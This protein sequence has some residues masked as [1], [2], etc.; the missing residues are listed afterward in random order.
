MIIATQTPQVF[1][2]RGV[3]LQYRRER[4]NKGNQDCEAA[5][6]VKQGSACC[7]D[8]RGADYSKPVLS[9]P[10][11][12]LQRLSEGKEKPSTEAELST[13]HNRLVPEDSKSSG[14]LHF[15]RERRQVV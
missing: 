14:T 3:R 10:S 5:V 2:A 1:T 7:F 11:K 6:R 15:P 9:S 8:Q 12:W 4:Q 13:Q